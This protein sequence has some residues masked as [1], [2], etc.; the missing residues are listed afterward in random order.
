[1]VHS[2][3][4]RPPKFLATL[5]AGATNS[6]LWLQ[7]CGDPGQHWLKGQAEQQPK[8]I[9]KVIHRQWLRGQGSL[10][11]AHLQ[12]FMRL[13]HSFAVCL[14]PPVVPIFPE[15][16]H[17]PPIEQEQRTPCSQISGAL[18]DGAT[19]SWCRVW[20]AWKTRSLL[21]SVNSY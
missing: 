4:C 16:A 19:V 20:S 15:E 11:Q 10:M 13:P 9:H 21:Q 2:W 18:W 5:A 3:L 14:L 1:M 17:S 8:L 7:K 12:L 6:K